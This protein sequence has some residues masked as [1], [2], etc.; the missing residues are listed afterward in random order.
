M[1]LLLKETKVNPSSE[2]LVSYDVSK[3]ELY[4]YIEI[5]FD[6][7]IY[8]TEGNIANKVQNIKIHFLELDELQRKYDFKN[9]R[10]ICE[11]IGGYELKLLKVAENKN[12]L[13]S[14]VSSEATNKGK[15]IESN[16]SEKS[17]IKDARLIMRI[18]QLDKTRSSIAATNLFHTESQ[19]TQRKNKA[20]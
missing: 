11:P 17:D 14:Y 16:D 6:G 8:S 5:L 12:Y 7:N 9:I 10:V 13:K 2:L 15:I 3:G 1:K 20:N 19:G 4:Y 18:A